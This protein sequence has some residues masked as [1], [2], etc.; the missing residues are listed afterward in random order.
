M[1][2]TGAEAL[3][4]VESMREVEDHKMELASVKKSIQDR[5]EKKQQEEDYKKHMKADGYWHLDDGTRVDP[6][7]GKRVDGVNSHAQIQSMV[8]KNSSDSNAKTALSAS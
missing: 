2:G 4:P 7:T 3:A 5:E 6:A 1:T 8:Q